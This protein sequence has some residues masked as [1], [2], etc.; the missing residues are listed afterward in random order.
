MSTALLR[1][2]V[3]DGLYIQCSYKWK[4]GKSLDLENPQS[5]N[6]KLQWLKLYDRREWYS[7]LVDKYE[8]RKFVEEKIGKDYLIPIIGVW[9]RFE[10]ID[11]EKLPKQFVLKCT[12]DSGGV[13]VCPDKEKFDFG[14]AQRN[15]NKWL[16]RNYYHRSKE[17]PYK[18]V[19]P[20]IICEK[21]MAD[22]SG[23]QLKDYK[24]F[25][26]NGEPKIIQVDFDRFKEHKKNM[27]DPQW[28]YVH[29]LCKKE[30]A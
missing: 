28:N 6:E 5:F 27:Y 25:C 17:W 10:D 18:N 4:T 24:V 11:L 1:R 29:I 15:I 9:D 13:I 19:K 14:K 20:R 2:V 30:S 8:V 7:S 21:Y 26:F 22:E 23:T 12:H 16:K 3:T